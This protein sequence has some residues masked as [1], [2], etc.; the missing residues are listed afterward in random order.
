[1]VMRAA[2]ALGIGNSP[3][4]TVWASDA[5]QNIHITLLVFKFLNNNL[6]YGYSLESPLQ[7]MPDR[8][9]KNISPF[10]GCKIV[11]FTNMM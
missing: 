4:G 10:F 6:G 11:L 9:I 3:P 8:K 7:H 1:M 5:E 2:A